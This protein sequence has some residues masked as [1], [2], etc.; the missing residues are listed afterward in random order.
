MSLASLSQS[1]HWAGRV[2]ASPP[3]RGAGIPRPLASPHCPRCPALTFRELVPR[4]PPARTFRAASAERTRHLTHSLSRGL[5]QGWGPLSYTWEWGS[6]GTQRCVG[7][8]LTGQ[9]MWPEDR[10]AKG[11]GRQ[12]P[13]HLAVSPEVAHLA[14]GAAQSQEPRGWEKGLREGSF[15]CG[16]SQSTPHP[17]PPSRGGSGQC[18]MRWGVEGDAEPSLLHLPSVSWAHLPTGTGSGSRG[19]PGQRAGGRGGHGRWGRCCARALSHR[20]TGGQV[21]WHLESAAAETACHALDATEPCQEA[22]KLLLA[23]AGQDPR[24]APRDP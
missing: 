14:P 22:E 20:Q 12:V 13:E 17:L 3:L 21:C 2:P 19:S 1:L 5:G 24:T 11:C 4:R 9:E 23:S 15:P 18:P 16:W 7:E 6:Q 8:G 10:G